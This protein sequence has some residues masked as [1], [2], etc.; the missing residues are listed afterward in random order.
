MLA[1]VNGMLIDGTGAAPI[2]DAA[3][4]IRAGRIAAVGPRAEVA[5]PP[6]ARII[7]VQGATI[8]PGFI[9]A[10]VHRGYHGHN[11]EAWAQAGV[12]TV[13]DLGASP[14]SD[15]FSQRD[16]LLK[17]DRYA[18]LI[19]AGPIVTVPNGYPMVPWGLEGLAVT[20]PEDAAL[21]VNRLLDEGADVVKIALDSGGSFGIEIP[22][23]SAEEAATIVRVA[24]ERGTLVSAHVLSSED[25][26]RALDAGVDDIAHMVSNDLPDHLIEKM[27]KADVYWVPTLELW[28]RVGHGNDQR[29][30]ANLRRFV[31]AGGKV[32]L[33]TDYAGYDAVFDLGMP[34]TE[35][36]LMQ[37]AGM[38]PMQ[39]IV[40][41]ARHAAYVCN[42]ENELGA[43]AVRRAADV[44]VVN[45][46]L[47][48]DIHALTQV[49]LVVHNGQVIRE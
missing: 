30:I 35:M 16:A 12:T 41:G 9:N 43:L 40:A 34:I 5:L 25:L 8:L 17:E 44:L 13:R 3:L 24:H 46:E 38:T 1:L 6:D 2:P 36:E 21:K 26:E 45:G 37:E 11:L 33:G 39:I 23:L 48:E 47:L 7:D 14:S 15:R 27:L 42:R 28:K 22:V 4:V 49:R 10:H 20:S 18:R 32:A 19:A 29:A 31:A